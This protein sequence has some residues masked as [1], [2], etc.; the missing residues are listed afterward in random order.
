[1]NVSDKTGSASLTV[2]RSLLPNPFDAGTGSVLQITYDADN[3]KVV[4]LKVL[5]AKPSPEV[6]T[7]E[8]TA[9]LMGKTVV[10]S[11][12]IVDLYQGSTFYKLTID[13]GSG[14]L[15]VFIPKSSAGDKTFSKGGQKV[16]IGGYVTEYRGGTVEVVPYMS[17][18]IVIE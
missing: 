4:S 7:G 5:E 12:T 3:K 14:G 16:R 10:V 11:G 17:D 8:V 13:D 18:A 1:M 9:N 15:V 2:D 6:K